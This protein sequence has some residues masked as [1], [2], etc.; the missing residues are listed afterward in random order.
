MRDLGKQFN[1][2]IS[3]NMS[4]IVKK[5][6][7]KFNESS[8][9]KVRIYR[10]TVIK[11]LND[12]I[13]KLPAFPQ[14]DLAY[15][16]I[17]INKSNFIRYLNYYNEYESVDKPE[18]A[19]LPV[20]SAFCKLFNI[21]IL[22][23]S[24]DLSTDKIN[25]I[26]DVKLGIT[27]K[28]VGEITKSEPFAEEIN[29]FDK[30]SEEKLT[31]I[32]RGAK[33]N[34]F[35]SGTTMTVVNDYNRDFASLVD[36]NVTIVLVIPNYN[37]KDI[38][39][40]LKYFYR[41]QEEY[42][43]KRKIIFN[44]AVNRMRG[45]KL[46]VKVIELDIFN[47]VAYFAVDYKEKLPSSR[48][49]VGYYLL[50]TEETLGG[51]RYNFTL[52]PGM[53][54]Y[55]EHRKQIE[56]IE[57]NLPKYLKNDT[58]A[59]SST[60]IKDTLVTNRAENS[61]LNFPFLD[62]IFNENKERY[63]LM[64]SQK[65][66]AT[67]LIPDGKSAT[68]HGIFLPINDNFKGSVQRG[69]YHFFYEKGICRLTANVQ[70]S[71]GGYEKYEG[72]AM[73]LDPNQSTGNCWAF[74]KLDH[75][76]F[77]ELA[78]LCFRLR[79][80]EGNNWETRI[81]EVITVRSHDSRPFVFRLLLSKSPL[82]EDHEYVEYFKGHL[83]LNTGKIQ[84]SKDKLNSAINH[85]NGQQ[86]AT[87]AEAAIFED[88]KKHFS[89]SDSSNMFK[90]FQNLK[91]SSDKTETIITINCDTD[92]DDGISNMDIFKRNPP[93]FSWLRKHSL[94][95]GHNQILSKLDKDVEEMLKWLQENIKK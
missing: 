80:D 89:N 19:P 1:V 14:Q 32:I 9:H 48:I 79:G 34:I 30:A 53:K 61:I 92:K 90:V 27:D 22:D 67:S 78:V 82:V 54:H 83:K 29:Y 88:L 85:F 59:V 24:T 28:P 65:D 95:P 7:D 5:Y 93:V 47:P 16:N 2:K 3:K 35:I 17:K 44:E 60:S 31:N 55:E 10:E 56:F 63:V 33:S 38:I 50:A 26:I 75:E 39:A 8:I 45:K 43:K 51:R 69:E 20:I 70:N 23:L 72:F 18:A 13:V 91:S 4:E 6:V 84:I 37:N 94:S 25:E 57:N 74:L 21:G 64:E 68:Y 41:R 11:E 76:E 81:S 73:L 15:S 77:S 58:E 86:S 40:S 49:N 62:A 12:I 71:E 36:K 46:S 66:L 52:R 87:E 42:F